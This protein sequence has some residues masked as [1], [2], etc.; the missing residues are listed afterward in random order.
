MNK[1]L[2]RAPAGI[3]TY[4]KQPAS[5]TASI[6]HHFHSS[7]DR[8]RL[9]FHLIFKRF[10]IETNHRWRYTPGSSV[11]RW[12]FRC[13]TLVSHLFL[14]SGHG[15]CSRGSMQRRVHQRWRSRRIVH[16]LHRTFKT[17]EEDQLFYR[18]KNEEAFSRCSVSRSV[19]LFI[20]V[21]Q[22]SVPLVQTTK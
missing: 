12:C 21:V 2:R 9:S 7:L 3:V 5:L 15:R 16:L 14:L 6:T 22:I 13:V 18:T 11:W 4:R 17:F 8:M 1:P 20:T 10:L 19:S